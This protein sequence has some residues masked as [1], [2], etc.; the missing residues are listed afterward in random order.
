MSQICQPSR[1]VCHSLFSAQADKLQAALVVRLRGQGRVDG[2]EDYVEEV[3][4]SLAWELGWCHDL[5]L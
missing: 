4:R 5:S 2:V 3:M 1:T